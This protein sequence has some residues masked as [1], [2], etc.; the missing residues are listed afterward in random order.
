ME[1]KYIMTGETKTIGSCTLYRIQAVRDFGYVKAGYR[2]GW[3]EKK[4]NLSHLGMCWVHEDAIVCGNAGVY[5]NAMVYNNA[6]VCD[7]ANIH[8]NALVCDNVIVRDNAN[9]C[10]SA[11]A[12]SNAKIYDNAEI[13]D[14]ALINA[15]SLIFGVARVGG[16]ARIGSHGSISSPNDY[17]VVGPIGSRN[18]YTTFYR[19]KEGILVSCGCFNGSIEAF[20]ERVKDA[21]RGNIHETQYLEAISYAEHLL[22]VKS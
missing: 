12:R 11:M 9:I 17:L 5:E 2:G 4:E 15:D 14:N 7:N 16:R 22:S 8:G 21:H 10:G 18:D 13:Y 1:R 3:I 6:V 19:T 20:E